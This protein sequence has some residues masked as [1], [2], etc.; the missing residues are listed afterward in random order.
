MT[1][2]SNLCILFS[3]VYTQNLKKS[4]KEKN[5]ATLKDFNNYLKIQ[6]KYLTTDFVNFKNSFFLN[7]IVILNN[8]FKRNNSKNFFYYLIF[9][10]KKIKTNFFWFNSF[11]LN[12]L[13]WKT[14]KNLNSNNKVAESKSSKEESPYQIN[15]QSSLI[16]KNINTKKKN[17]SDFFFLRKTK[18]FNKGRYSRNRQIYRTGVYLCLYINILAIYAIYFLFYRFTFNFGFI[19]LFIFLGSSSFFFSRFFKYNFINNFFFNLNFF[20]NWLSALIYSIYLFVIE[21]FKKIFN[22]L[23]LIF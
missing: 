15:F 1:K 8:F 21:F 19:W 22:F 9:L 23:N 12:S 17:F 2:K 18:I 7:D 16:E 3:F 6:N 5:R 20:F 13:S 11:S 10:N 14:L 4:N